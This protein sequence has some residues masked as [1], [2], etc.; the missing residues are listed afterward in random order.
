[1]STVETHEALVET[2][3]EIL[4]R[5]NQLLRSGY[6]IGQAELIATHTEVDLHEACGLVAS[7]CDSALAVRILL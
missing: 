1:M 5:L 4:W 3:P 7:G 6:S 2:P